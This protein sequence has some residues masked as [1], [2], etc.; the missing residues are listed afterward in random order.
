ME[1]FTEI[2]KVESWIDAQWSKEAEEIA[3]F[4]RAESLYGGKDVFDS[5]NYF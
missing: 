5:E 4:W 1:G 2:R 3:N